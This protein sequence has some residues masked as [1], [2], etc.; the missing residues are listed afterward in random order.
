MTRL[1]ITSTRMV[2]C[3]EQ[4]QIVAPTNEYRKV[5]ELYGPAGG[6]QGYYEADAKK[7]AYKEARENGYT[8]EV[9]Y[10]NDYGCHKW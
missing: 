6:Y 1:K 4:E 10:I 9:A 3:G 5:Y 8:V 2:D 7:E